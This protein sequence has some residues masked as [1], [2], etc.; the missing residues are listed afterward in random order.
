MTVLRTK[1][2]VKCPKTGKEVKITDRINGCIVCDDMG[3][4][5]IEGKYVLLVACKYIPNPDLVLSK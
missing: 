2:Y 4:V 5:S 1:T 3:P